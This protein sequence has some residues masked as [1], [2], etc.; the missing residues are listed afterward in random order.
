M[1]LPICR[2]ADRGLLLAV[3][4]W[5]AWVGGASAEPCDWP[6]W[7]TFSA[8]FIQ[9]DGRV[10]AD[11]SE[12][13]YSSSEGQ[14]Y[15]AFFALVNNDRAGFER[16]LNWT[17]DN[18]AAGDWAARLPAWQ[19]G[20][21]PDGGWGV[22]DAN[23]ASDA[24][25]WLAY[26]LLEAG[27]LWHEPRF[28]AQGRLLLANLR[29]YAVRT[30]PAVGTMLLP[31]R[32][33]FEV[34]GGGIRVN[35]S[36]VPVQLLRALMRHD[37]EG[38]W[39]AVLDNEVR[40]LKAATPRGFVPDWAEYQ[41][42][43]GFRLDRQSGGVGQHDAIRVYLWWGMLSRQ[44]VLSAELQASL[45]GMNRLI[46]KRAISPPLAIDTQTGQG[47]GVSPPGFSAALLPYFSR[48]G[49]REA[50]RLQRERLAARADA[51]GAGDELRYYDQVLGLFGLGWMEQ[52]FGF[53]SQGQLV[54]PWKASCSVKK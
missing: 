19:W 25:L 51:Q 35:P 43:V 46:P 9:S 29:L 4:F 10:L 50:L 47:K 49:N 1:Q 13:R 41:P 39:R 42:D 53:S 12:Q 36:Y 2:F 6:L 28:S 45:S 7:Q 37:P 18:L 15:A 38:P 33:G 21:K 34:D 24:D 11:E 5:M 44:D 32:T 27:R 40:L 52:R 16:I 14:A 48:T 8:R 31:G 3:L 22:V 17:R 26:S 23:S 54:V 20:R 30:F